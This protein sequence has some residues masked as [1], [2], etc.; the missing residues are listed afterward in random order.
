MDIT[1]ADEEVCDEWFGAAQ[2]IARLNDCVFVVNKTIF[3]VTG[4][5]THVKITVIVIKILPEKYRV[6]CQSSQLA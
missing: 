2:L 3:R 6:R 4:I 1:D 5:E